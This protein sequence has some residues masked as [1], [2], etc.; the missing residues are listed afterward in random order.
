MIGFGLIA[1]IV[2]FAAMDNVAEVF[3]ARD[4]LDAGAWGYG[5]LASVWIVGMVIGS[6]QIARRLRPSS[7]MPA[8]ALAAIVGGVAVATA[9]AAGVMAIALALFVVGGVANGVITVSMR[10]IIVHRVPDRSRGRVFAAYGGLFFGTQLAAM[11]VAGGLVAALG[12]QTVLHH[13]RHRNGGRRRDR[14]AGVPL[15]AGVDPSD[16]R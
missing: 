14:A 8:L 10:S 6:S 12:G 3:F 16:A 2:L 4:T 15:P 11:A 13:R 5:V 9:G 1:I 7:L